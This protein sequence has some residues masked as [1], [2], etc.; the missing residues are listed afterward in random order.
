MFKTPPFIFDAYVMDRKYPLQDKKT[1][2]PPS[3][4][5]RQV[6]VK[7]SQNEG[8]Y[9][10]ICDI[11]QNK[12]KLREAKMKKYIKFTNKVGKIVCTIVTWQSSLSLYY[13][14]KPPVPEFENNDKVR[15]VSK[16]SHDGI[17]DYKTKIYNINDFEN[18]AMPLLELIVSNYVRNT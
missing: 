14:V 15:N 13:N 1:T 6:N 2:P 12:L 9:V 8:L 4:Q 3:I 10:E 17:G 18:V 5:Q 16:L 7:N 11:L